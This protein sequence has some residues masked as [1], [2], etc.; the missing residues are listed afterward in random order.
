MEK[1]DKKPSPA[2]SR[3]DFIKRTSLGVSM[4]GLPVAMAACGGSDGSDSDSSTST[5]TS[6]SPTAAFPTSSAWKFGV[7]ADTQWTTVTYGDDGENPH[8]CAVDIINQLNAQFIAA[9]VKFVVQVGDLCDK[10]NRTSSFTVTKS[11]GTSYSSTGPLAE[12]TRAAFTQ[13]LFNAGIGFFPLR[14]NHDD[15]STAATEFQRIFPQTQNGVHNAT[16]SDVLSIT[17]PDATEQPIIAK[18]GSSFTIG[19]NFSSPSTGLTGLSYSFDY[20]NMRLMLL[21]QFEPT[22][23]TNADGN[24]YTDSSLSSTGYNR[25]VQAQQTWID[26]QLSGRTSGTHAMV[27][28]HKGLVTEDHEDVLFGDCP[29][30]DS[31]TVGSTVYYG[32]PKMDTFISS[33]SSNDVKLLICGHD[34]MHDHSKVSTIDGSAA[35]TQIVGASN[36]NKFYFPATTA[37]DVTYCSGKR[38]TLISHERNTIGYY[39]VTV[40]GDN[41]CVDY[42]SAAAY[43]SSATAGTISTT[44]T[45]SFT[46]RERFGY[47]LGGKEFIVAQMGTFTSVTDTGPGGT[48]MSI[49]EGNNGNSSFDVSG[50]TFQ[51]AV[52]TGWFEATSATASDVLL[53][54]GMAYTMGSTATDVYV[55]SMT[56]DPTKVTSAQIEAGNFALATVDNGSW[57]NAVSG[58]SSSASTFVNG[59]WKS[60][61]SLGTWGVDTSSSTVWAVLD[62]NG[63]FAAVAGI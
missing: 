9:G 2:L 42:Y 1:Q 24:A 22:D 29:A 23:S 52:N 19:S 12:E 11:D 14:G 10:G 57:V 40:D 53:L 62:Y 50:R 21:D 5:T 8:T 27:F 16:P 36:S 56:Y 37:N 20:S 49:L 32:S 55:L 17:N 34:H 47:G 54:Q 35:V 6:A 59:A 25:S 33:L 13:T 18:T 45:L 26:A 31:I 60:G 58:N 39:I 41:V 30:A 43:P 3:R 48:V 28:S 38:Q 51:C 15:G 61:Y 46:W 7:M 63:Y 44:P 4:L